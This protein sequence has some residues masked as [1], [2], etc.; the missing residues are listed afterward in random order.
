MPER[1]LERTVDIVGGDFEFIPFG[2]WRRIWPGIPLAVRMVHLIIGSL[3]N[4]FKWR[5]PIEVERNGV[6]MTEKFGVTLVKAVPL[7]ALPTPI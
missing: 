5:L 3:L 2:A 4:Q 7:H 1:F 6:D